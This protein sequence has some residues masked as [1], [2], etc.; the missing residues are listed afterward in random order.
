MLLVKRVVA[1]GIL[2]AAVLIAAMWI[3]HRSEFTIPM[4][5]GPYAV[6]RSVNDWVSG[7]REMLVWMWYP[8][9]AEKSADVIQDHAPRALRAPQEPAGP[10]ILRPLWWLMQLTE[11]DG[12]AVRE[13]SVEDGP[14]S[15]REP[16]YPVVLM[17]GGAWGGV[18]GYSILAED[19]ASRGYIVIGF[20]VPY[21]TNRV[22]F[23]DGRVIAGKPENN[24]E[25]ADG[26]ELTV[27]A[28]RL[29]RE[30]SADMTLVVDHLADLNAHDPSGRFQGRVDLKH[31]GAFGHS[32]GGAESLQF[33]HDDSRCKAVL[34][35]D[36]GMWGSFVEDGVTQPMMLLTS[37]H[38]GESDP[39]TKGI[40]AAFQTF[41]G[42]M[43]PE[44]TTRLMIRGANHYLFSDDALLRSRIL[45]WALRRLHVIGIDGPRQVEV[46]KYGIHTFFDAY[47][48]GS[49][50]APRFLTPQYPELQP[51]Q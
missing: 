5:E 35:L 6:G 38:T 39:E 48:K 16:A 26:P 19:L 43:P 15:P 32:L 17:R 42:H 2:A 36:G 29:A 20:D 46:A 30:W 33:C 40:E 22:V 10:V 27:L 12:S 4:P 9:A 23:P 44:R 51:L 18:S 47:L 34:D 49:G 21:R 3:E 45:M 8:A 28:A 24:P 1:I 25:E 11:R 50:A 37:D 7:S 31:I 41:F 14:V 13:H